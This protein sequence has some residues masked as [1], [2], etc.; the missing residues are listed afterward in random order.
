MAF[1]V[2]S[3]CS[4]MFPEGNPH[5]FGGAAEF[6]RLWISSAQNCVFMCFFSIFT[7]LFIRVTSAMIMYDKRTL[8][9]IG[10]CY[11]N[12]IQ[13]TLYTDP[14]W[15]LEILRSTEAD[16]GRL[17]NTRRR[18]KHRGKRA[19]IRNRLRKRAHS[20]PL[21]SILL[22][23]VQSLDNKMDDLRA[24][25][26]FQRDIRDCNI[27]CLSETWLTPSVPDNAV[28]PSDNFSVFRMDRTAEAGKTRG[29]GVCFFINKKWCDPRNISILSRS[30]SP[31]LEHLSIICRPF[32]LPR[33]F[34]S[35][36]VTAVYIPPQADSSLALSKLHDELSGYINIHPDAA[37]IVAGDFNKANL[38]KVIPN[39]HQHISCPTR[40]LNT[41]DHCYTQFKNAY[42]AHSLPAF[43]KSEHAAIFLTPD[44]K[45]RILQEPPVEREVTRWSPH[46][47]ATLQ[48]SLDD[49][50]WDMF[51]ASSSDVSEFT[52]V[53]L[54]FVNTLT[55]QAT[56]TVTIKTFSNQKP[57]V[58]RSIRDAV[59]HRTAAYNAGIL[60]GN[61]SEY[62]S[63]CYALRRAVRAAKRR[64]SERIES[65]FQLNDSRRMWQGLKTICSSGNNNSVE[66][67]AD[68]LIAVELNNFYGRFECNSGTILPSSTSRSSRQSS[69]DYAI[70][71]SEDDVRRELRRVNVRK[72]AGPDGITGRVLRSCAD[73]LAGLFTSIFNESLTTSVVPTPFKKSVIIPVPKNSKPSCLNDYRP[74][75]LTSTVMKV[76]ERLLKKHIC[77]SIP[78]TLDPLQFAYRPNRST[79]DAI[80][81]V[82]HSSLTHIDSKNGNYVRL[83]FI[84]YSSA[85][86]TIVPTKLAVKLSDLSLNTSLCD[87]IQDFLTARPQVVK[88]GQFTSNS[89]TLNI[90]APQGCVLSPLLYSLYTHDC[91]SSHSS[92]SI[93]KFA[94]DTVVLGLINND[95][96]TAYLDEVERLT[97]WCQD[98]CLSLNVSKTKELIVD[99]RK[100]QQ[101]PYTPLMISGTPVERVSSFKYLG[102]NIS[103]DLTWTTHIQTQVKKARQRLYHL[104]QLRKFRVS[105]AILKTF[106]SGAIES[107]L[108]QCIS[109]WYNNATNQDC[110]ALQRV[111]R[112]AERISGSTLPS[113]QVI[114]LKRCR[115]RAAKITKDSNHPGNHLFRLLPSGRR[116]RSLMAKTERLRKSFF[117]QAIRLLNTNSVP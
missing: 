80:S 104:R 26:S 46:S 66:V 62:K 106:Y 112:L 63:S 54:S 92:T 1:P 52:E 31:H 97:S 44:Y 117:P 25:I 109:V 75:A 20:P 8:L 14:A 83:L 18:R 68:P 81:Q 6:S 27:I 56:E 43:G 91:V 33:E 79:D 94:D 10:Q 23:N 41:L 19:G 32:Y 101:R 64:Y 107:V 22:A 11:T 42:K 21:P 59:N 16:K 4:S 69:N 36:V 87:W 88:V 53:A 55:E 29:G 9:D 15:P 84:D 40:G 7:S 95:D 108:T 37:C 113:L 24:R 13:D 86:N 39:F 17:N 3:R 96:E 34:S 115:S 70:T 30:C 74:V 102:V 51:R 100:R 99:F 73:Q 67:R 105:P 72:A 2:A 57:W 110:K 77:S 93:I 5:P 61:M 60:S 103:E 114:Y 111:V 49:V 85:F 48:A 76:F 38:K 71:L 50:D 82:L 35:T 28:T 90:G 89:I 116:Y 58:D 78:A 45:Q 65:H 12:L 98:N 47:E